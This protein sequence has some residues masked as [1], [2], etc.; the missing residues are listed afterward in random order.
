MTCTTILLTCSRLAGRVTLTRAFS[1][2][3]KST[4]IVL[5]LVGAVVW[6]HDPNSIEIGTRLSMGGNL[7]ETN[8]C[9]FSVNGNSYALVYRKGNIDLCDRTR[10]GNVVASFNNANLATIQPT[11]ARL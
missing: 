2:R 8:M 7:H 6:R 9:W 5:T 10:A 3:T 1:T 11:F 4:Q